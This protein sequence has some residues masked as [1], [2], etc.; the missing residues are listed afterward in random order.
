MAPR[1]VISIAK[2]ILFCA[3]PDAY[4]LM[5]FHA[6]QEADSNSIMEI[7]R[8]VPDVPV[9]SGTG[10][11]A[12]NIIQKLEA[13]DGACV[14]TTFKVDGKFDNHIDPE[15]VKEFMAQVAVFRREHPDIA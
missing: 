7:R 5:G 12:H 13:S 8:A 4:C 11:K 2:S 14:G 6:G 9:F 15:R 3:R 1:D 10:C